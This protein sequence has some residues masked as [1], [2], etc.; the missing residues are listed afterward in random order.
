M[1]I[2]GVVAT[3]IESRETVFK[4]REESRERATLFYS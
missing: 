2:Q 1:M 3:G 4:S